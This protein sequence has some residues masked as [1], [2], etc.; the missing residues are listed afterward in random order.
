MGGEI[1]AESY[2]LPAVLGLNAL[3]VVRLQQKFKLKVIR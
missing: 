2:P 1:S 3:K